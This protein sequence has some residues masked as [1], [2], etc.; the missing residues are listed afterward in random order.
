MD[1]LKQ[2][3]IKWGIHSVLF[4][5]GGAVLIFFGTWY[6]YQSKLNSSPYGMAIGVG[7]LFIGISF[8]TIVPGLPK[9]Y[10]KEK[11]AI[12][13]GMD[14]KVVPLGKDEKQLLP[15]KKKIPPGI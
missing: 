10:R 15:P 8:L 9:R 13:N 1:D 14:A 4:T 3:K 6:L 7:V 2:N 5:L 11:Q 12:I